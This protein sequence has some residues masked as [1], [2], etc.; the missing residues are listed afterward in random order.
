M[1]QIFFLPLSDRSRASRPASLLR[2]VRDSFAPSA[3]F[4]RLIRLKHF[5]RRPTQ[6]GPTVCLNET[7]V[8]FVQRKA[9]ATALRPYNASFPKVQALFRQIRIRL[10]YDLS[11][12]L[13]AYGT[14][15]NYLVH[16][17]FEKEHS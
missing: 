4:Q 2:T 1:M 8:A 12:A 6:G 7:P 5:Q 14:Q 17:C 10:H 3:H 9:R 11:I 16:L 15:S 13:V